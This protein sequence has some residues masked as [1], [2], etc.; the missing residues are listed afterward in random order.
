MPLRGAFLQWPLKAAFAIGSLRAKNGGAGG[1]RTLVHKTFEQVLYTLRPIMAG[2][3]R[4]QL[5]SAS[6][7]FG[8][9]YGRHPPPAP[10][11]CT[12]TTHSP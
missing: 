1:N 11:P 12:G 4:L 5:Y 7:R 2:L 10:F 9:A 3:A 8:D 6:S